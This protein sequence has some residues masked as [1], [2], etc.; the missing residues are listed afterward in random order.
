[1]PLADLLHQIAL[2]NQNRREW[3]EHDT[4]HALAKQIHEEAEELVTAIEN[5]DSLPQGVF[6]VASEVGDILY[7]T[8]KL[9]HDLGLDPAQVTEMKLLRNGAKYTDTFHNNGWGYDKAREMSKS[10]W[11]HLG[12]DATFWEWY[13]ISFGLGEDEGPAG[14]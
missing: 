10:L 5:Y 6:E 14:S 12:G 1:M 13:M 8:L 9:C 2:Q 3:V 7:L 11:D 4:P